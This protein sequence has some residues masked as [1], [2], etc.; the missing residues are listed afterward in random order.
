MKSGR[1]VEQAA[2][3]TLFQTPQHPYT[4]ELLSLV[5]TLDRIRGEAAAA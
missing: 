3:E 4:Q 5:P 1:L 2:A